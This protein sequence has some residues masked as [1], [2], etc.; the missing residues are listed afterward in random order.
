MIVCLV[1]YLNVD[2]S[3]PISTSCLSDIIHMTNV[4]RL[5][6][7]KLNTWLKS[8]K[9]GGG[10]GTKLLTHCILDSCSLSWSLPRWSWERERV[11]GLTAKK[12]ALRFTAH[13]F[14]VGHQP[15]MSTFT[16]CPHHVMFPGLTCFS[17]LFRF[18]VLYWMQI[19][20]QKWERPGSVARVLINV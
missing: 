2:P 20:E 1:H 14:V 13:V 12:L 7:I 18:H 19:K 8:A 5:V 6:H 10:L 17:P 9:N 15:P 11:L 16:L 4:P 3:S